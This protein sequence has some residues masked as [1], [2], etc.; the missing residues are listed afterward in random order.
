[1][2]PAWSPRPLYVTP[3]G[4]PAIRWKIV[5]GGLAARIL[6]STL[7][8]LAPPARGVI[9]ALLRCKLRSSTSCLLLI[10]EPRQTRLGSLSRDSGEGEVAFSLS[11]PAGRPVSTNASGLLGPL[12]C[13]TGKPDCVSVFGSVTANFCVR[14]YSVVLISVPSS[15][16][17]KTTEL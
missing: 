6:S 17:A 7:S 10:P 4:G 1:M 9:V 2:P 5:Y 13:G 11:P 15:P 8:I 14:P 12:I 3:A 16:A